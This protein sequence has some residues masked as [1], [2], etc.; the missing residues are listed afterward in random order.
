MHLYLGS[1]KV[2]AGQPVTDH[3]FF[4]RTIIRHSDFVTRVSG[5]EGRVEGG[6]GP[7]AEFFVPH[8]NKGVGVELNVCPHQWGR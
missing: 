7:L 5:R 8:E 4:I 6:G 3:R 1:A 2:A